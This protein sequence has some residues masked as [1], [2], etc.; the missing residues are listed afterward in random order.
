MTDY[1]TY[2][3]S[4][5]AP[6][7]FMSS[8]IVIDNKV[9]GY[10]IAQLPL[11]KLS[12]LTE[13]VGEGLGKTGESY[14]VGDD[15]LLRSDTRRH[16]DVFNVTASFKEPDTHHVSSPSVELAL[17][18]ETGVRVGNNY[19]QEEVISAYSPMDIAGHR[20]V[21]IIEESLDE[22]LKPES[23]LQLIFVIMLLASIPVIVLVAWWLASL[24][25]KPVLALTQIMK[26][27][28]NRWDF[29]LR[30][31]N[32][33]QDE[34][35]QASQTFNSMVDSLQEAI[36]T[37]NRSMNN[38]SGGHFDKKITD[39]MQGDLGTLKQAANSTSA[40]LEEVISSIVSVMT[41]IQKGNFQQRIDRNTSGQLAELTTKINRTSEKLEYLTSMLIIMARAINDG[42]LDYRL[43]LSKEMTVQGAYEDLE[44][45]LNDGL[46]QLEGVV[47]T[48]QH[49]SSEVGSQI[50]EINAMSISMLH[51]TKE[52]V[53]ATH[54]INSQL[55]HWQDDV[56]HLVNDAK[57]G[58]EIVNGARN[59]A[60]RVSQ[61]I[62]GAEA[63]ILDIREVSTRI[64]NVAKG[65]TEVATQTTM[66]ALN[67]AIEATKAGVEGKGF[68]VVADEV[69]VLADQ[70]TKAA[71]EI[72]KLVEETFHKVD[73]G[74]SSVGD[75]SES[76]DQLNGV[77]T[78]VG[79]SMAHMEQAILKQQNYN[80]NITESI[81]SIDEGSR[82]SKSSVET[83]QIAC[84]DMQEKFLELEQRLRALKTSSSQ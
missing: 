21:M 25:L 34:I 83:V 30:T 28:K 50:A 16:K 38:F 31:E 43:D 10:F 33:H 36:N 75:V 19:H 9:E 48:V 77:L 7:S 47:N 4:Y 64:G 5:E 14:L 56:V 67:A 15:H 52:Q 37:I 41:S 55:S 20:W 22:A 80:Q 70:S 81:Q 2:Q 12:K 71:K 72:N 82:S 6:A 39:D 44:T 66:L 23:R 61:V 49:V 1:Q 53:E 26:A 42:Q 84:S 17:Q 3:P 68:T 29:S 32:D 11:S 74:V 46:N 73:K 24:Q 79:E 51:K 27:V 63:A 18:G 78:N 62:D 69:R 58:G 40:E 13:V 59:E 54:N 35:G 76:F 57:Q 8:P 45:T 65:I 60:E